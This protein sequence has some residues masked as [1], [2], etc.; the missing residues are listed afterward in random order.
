[1][2]SPYE[3]EWNRFGSAGFA[4]EDEIAKAGMFTQ[5]PDSMF[6]GFMGKR[7]LWYHGAGGMV[8]I[9][10]ARGGKLRDILGYNVCSGIAAKE[11]LVVLDP[12]GELAAISQDQTPDE[13]F[14]IYWNPLGLHGLPAHRINPVGHI[15]AE[16]RTLVSDVKVYVENAIPLS[17]SA[18]GQYFERRAQ[19]L[20]EG[21]ILTLVRVKGVLLLPDLYEVINLIPG[22]GEDWKDFAFEMSESGFPISRRIEEEIATARQTES[23]GFQGILGELF[24]AFAC[25]SDPVL[26]ASVSPPFDFDLAKLCEGD[27]RYQF[28]IMPPAEFIEPWSPVIKALFV[29]VMTYKSRAPSAPR[30]TWILDECA[31]LGGFP[32][33]VKMFTYGAGIGIRPWA[34]FQSAQQMN[35]LGR[36]AQDIIMS[37]AAFQNWFAVRDLRTAQNLSQMLGAQSLRYDDDLRQA[38]ARH[39]KKRALQAAL[40]GG[41]PFNAGLEYAYQRGEAE[42]RSAQHR[43]LRTP[44]ELLGMEADKQVVFVDGLSHPLYADRRP[45]Y[46]E[47]FMAGRFHPNPYHP[48]CDR[49]RVRTLWGQAWRP[50][51]RE[52]VPA[53]FADYPQYAGGMWSR[54][55]A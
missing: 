49:V 23:G 37:S 47:R 28:Y 52:A 5:R 10:G 27:R 8:M 24:K 20:A 18:T 11:T 16:S 32:V 19:E 53:R 6:V 25:L 2:A 3:N 54:V 15:R 36:D 12:K 38:G 40:T 26:L 42:R 35:A 9:A 22:N 44:D 13:K 31:L 29:G 34:V 33:V 14:C 21:I 46:D 39:A 30:Q 45:Y 7:P 48:P 17:G 4:D 43:L 1:M 50:V 55:D 41:D 51:I